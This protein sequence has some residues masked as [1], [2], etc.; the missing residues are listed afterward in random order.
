LWV[1][2]CAVVGVV[3]TA[4]DVVEA[5]AAEPVNS[6]LVVEKEIVTAGLV[7]SLEGPVEE[8]VVEIEID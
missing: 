8:R 1:F 6:E 4:T 5:S 3:G 2:L 7:V